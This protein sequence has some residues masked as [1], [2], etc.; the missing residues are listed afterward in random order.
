MYHIII[1]TI[2]GLQYVIFSTVPP[3]MDENKEE[4][5]P[6]PSGILSTS[7]K[8]NHINHNNCNVTM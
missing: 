6:N 3:K 5:A 8:H 4:K 7:K 2:Y 1:P